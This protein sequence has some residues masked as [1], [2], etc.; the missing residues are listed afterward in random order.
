MALGPVIDHDLFL[1]EVSVDGTIEY[2]LD[3]IVVVACLGVP[4]SILQLFCQ[5]LVL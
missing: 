4:V 3:N 5:G 1:E 2:V